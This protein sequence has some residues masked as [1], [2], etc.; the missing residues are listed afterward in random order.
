MVK[1]KCF[2]DIV[3]MVINS[4]VYNSISSL[5]KK[6]GVFDRIFFVLLCNVTE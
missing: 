1:I 4:M 3:S 2:K 6:Y 5:E